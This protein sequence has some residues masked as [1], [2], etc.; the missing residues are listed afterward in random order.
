MAT[1]NTLCSD[2]KTYYRM[3]GVIDP[4]FIRAHEK[5]T[6]LGSKHKPISSALILDKFHEKASL[7]GLQ[8]ANEQCALQKKGRRFLYNA[9][10]TSD[11]IKN[12]DHAL[13]IGFANFSD[14]SKS[15]TG[16][17]GTR[18]FMCSNLCFHG[19]V[20]PA[21][22]RHTIGNYDRI[23]DKIGI[24]FDTF[25]KDKDTIEGQIQLMKATKLDDTILGKFVLG[26]ARQGNAFGNTHILDIA[27]FTDNPEPMLAELGNPTYNDKN[28]SSAYRLFNAATFIVNYK[29]KNAEAKI[30]ATKLVTDTLMG[31]LNPQYKPVGDVIDVE[32][33]DEE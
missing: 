14:R 30:Y 19:I 33:V 15:F 27:R 18:V 5:L 10:V 31:V 2:D 17:L 4:D 9:L 11:K 20:K 28:D 25:E 29:M 1:T 16:L 8:L 24:L 7:L 23:D 12:E 13:A 22:Q 6:S 3:D 32:P 26:L 21:C